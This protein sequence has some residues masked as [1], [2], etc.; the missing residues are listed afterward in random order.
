MKRKNIDKKVSTKEESKYVLLDT[1]T[2]AG[3]FGQIRNAS[4]SDL[5]P[6]LDKKL[7][8]SD[9]VNNGVDD[10]DRN[11]KEDAKVVDAT[12]EDTGTLRHQEKKHK[13]QLDDFHPSNTKLLD[14]MKK[15]KERSVNEHVR[16]PRM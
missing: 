7:D 8:M 12:K 5:K 1:S 11:E 16:M 13:F 14:S 2:L 3:L 6:I 4:V 9:S 10:I 15:T